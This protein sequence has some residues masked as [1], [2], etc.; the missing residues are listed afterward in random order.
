MGEKK[1][2][3]FCLFMDYDK[4]FC[5]KLF[6]E[7]IFCLCFEEFPALSFYGTLVC[8]KTLYILEW[9]NAIFMTRFREIKSLQN[10]IVQ[11]LNSWNE[12][13][14]LQHFI[15]RSCLELSFL[16]VF[17]NCCVLL[18][19]LIENV[20]LENHVTTFTIISSKEFLVKHFFAVVVGIMYLRQNDDKKS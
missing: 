17:Y 6:P 14:K 9:R 15:A 13:M 12:W 4:C 16:L 10:K 5:A 8:N 18:F 1:R 20:S 11:C 3:N 7:N 19:L 2:E